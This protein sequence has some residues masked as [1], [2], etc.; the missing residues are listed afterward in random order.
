MSSDYRCP[1]DNSLILDFEATCEKD[2]HDY[3]SEIIQFSVAVLNTREKII[4]EDVSFN[5]YVKP[6]INPKLTDFCAELTGI[7]QDTIDKADTFPEVYDQFTAWLEEHNFQEKRYA[8][9]CESRQDVWRRAQYQFL[10]NK[11]PLPAIFRQWVNLSFHYREDM[12]LAQRQDTVHQSFIEKMSAFYDIPFVGQA[13]NA[14][15]E[16]SFLAKVTKHILDNGKL[17]TINESLKC[18]AGFRRVPFNVDPQWKTSF[19]SSCKVFEAILPLVSTPTK[20]Y[21]IVDN[22]GKCLYCFNADC[23]G[24]EHKQ[25]PDYVYEQLKEPSV[26]AITAGLMKE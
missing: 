15:S 10:L 7:D 16:C 21:Y 6:I 9:V 22:Y 20:R 1:F 2:N 11:Q 8:F 17:V 19:D 13:H 12:R 26:V 18:I 5:K 24:L 4:R 3:P 25:Y 14:M 23:T